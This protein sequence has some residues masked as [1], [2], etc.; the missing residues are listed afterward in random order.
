MNKNEN[1]T[2]ANSLLKDI[3]GGQGANPRSFLFSG[4]NAVSEASQVQSLTL[5]R[6]LCS[7]LCN[8]GSGGGNGG[9]ESTETE[10]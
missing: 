8:G 9:G 3:I 7:C 2:L 4:F 5:G 6:C 1:F 10:R